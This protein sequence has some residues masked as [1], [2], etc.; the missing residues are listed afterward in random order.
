M[1]DSV[2]PCGDLGD[3]RLVMFDVQVGLFECLAHQHPALGNGVV[4]V[5]GITGLAA[6]CKCNDPGPNA[7]L[8]STIDLAPTIVEL[9]GCDVENGEMDGISLLDRTRQ[10]EFVVNQRW[11]NRRGE[12]DLVK[13][14]YP[15]ANWDWY[16]LG[17]VI[18]LRDERYK[19]VWTA[20]GSQFLFD[21]VSD[22]QEQHDLAGQNGTDLVRFE[23]KLKHWLDNLVVRE[24]LDEEL[25]RPNRRALDP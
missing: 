1:H 17:H 9:A 18:A 7:R 12:L 19:Y 16:D 22:P 15:H 24:G 8:T 23:R 13:S 14:K 20:R 25:L 3:Q 6:A 2:L 11:M 21:M 5:L 10:H 4:V